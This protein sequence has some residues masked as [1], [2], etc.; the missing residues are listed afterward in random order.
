MI[1]QL[2]TTDPFWSNP[3]FQ[4]TVCIAVGLIGSLLLRRRSA[5]A[6][7]VLFLAMIAAVAVPAMSM[8]VRHYE[9]GM[10]VGKPAV[11]KSKPAEIPIVP[12]T[13]SYEISTPAPIHYTYSP[14]AI[15][16]E[17]AMPAAAVVVSPTKAKLPLSTILIWSWIIVSTILGVRL[18]MTFILGLGMLRRALPM[19]IAKGKLGIDKPVQVLAGN[20]V[21]SP[22][23]W[24]WS[25]RPALLVPEDAEQFED[26][27]DWVGMFCHELAHWSRLDHISGLFAEIMV[28]VFPWHPL[29]WWAKSRLAGL[30]EQACDDWVVAGSHSPT[31]YAE[32][33]LDLSPQGQLSFLPAVVGRKNGLES[34]IRRIVKDKCGKPHLGLCWAVFVTLIAACITIGAAFAQTRPA[35]TDQGKEGEKLLSNEHK[36]EPHANE[37]KHEPH[38]EEHKHELLA[39]DQ[40]LFAQ[41]QELLAEEQQ[42]NQLSKQLK[43]KQLE[44]QQLERLGS[45]LQL[46]Q[47]KQKTTSEVEAAMQL[48]L[49]HLKNLNAL[50]QQQAKYRK[51]A[52]VIESEIMILQQEQDQDRV[53]KLAAEGEPGLVLDKHE[54]ETRQLEAEQLLAELKA[55]RAKINNIENRLQA[56]LSANYVIRDP[57]LQDVTS[58][59]YGRTTQSGLFGQTTQRDQFGQATR[60]DQFQQTTERDQLTQYKRILKIEADNLQQELE[61][62]EGLRQDEIGN[63]ETHEQMRATLE[64]IDKNRHR[65]RSN[66]PPTL[67]GGEL[68][69]DDEL[70]ILKKIRGDLQIHTDKTKLKIDRLGD[71]KEANK[72]RGELDNIDAFIQYIDGRINSPAVWPQQHLQSTDEY[73]AKRKLL[74]PKRRELEDRRKHDQYLLKEAP[75]SEDAA[76]IRHELDKIDK[77]IREIDF[78]LSSPEWCAEK[79]KAKLLEK[80]TTDSE[81]VRRIEQQKSEPSC[82]SCHTDNDHVN[83]EKATIQAEMNLLKAQLTELRKNYDAEIFNRESEWWAEMR[84]FSADVVAAKQ[85]IVVAKAVL[86]DDLATLKQM[87]QETEIFTI[88]NSVNL[89]TDIALYNKLKTMKANHDRLGEKIERDKRVL[90]KYQD[91]LKAAEDRKD[92]YR[93]YKPTADTKDEDT[94]YAIT[95]FDDLVT[96]RKTTAPVVEDQWFTPPPQLPPGRSSRRR[97]QVQTTTPPPHLPPGRSSRRRQQIQ[98]TTQALQQGQAYSPWQQPQEKQQPGEKLQSRINQLQDEIRRLRTEMIEMRKLMKDLVEHEKKRPGISNLYENPTD[99]GVKRGKK[100]LPEIPG[101]PLEP[102]YIEPIPSKKKL[103]KKPPPKMPGAPLEPENI[104]P[105]P[106]EN[107]P[108]E[109]PPDDIPNEP[110]E[111]ETTEPIPLD[112]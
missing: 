77:E 17:Y 48:R 58:N 27:V 91:E 87:Q 1:S 39:H 6:H 59:L 30:S 47:L 76:I 56:S 73:E 55:L 63:A 111:I 25:R 36:H 53:K 92:K 82:S 52:D 95:E 81:I 68:F 90:A 29:I 54:K 60:S 3:L 97:Q 32:S 38:A 74:L 61:F 12:I 71:K 33:L 9:L 85:R 21:S 31:D 4:S 110:D 15:E 8:I 7:Q 13:T 16:P 2:F 94:D 75:N 93:K 78:E 107:K 109:H 98:T 112:D 11:T 66:V 50:A 18:F 105:T 45:Q 69:K 62:L 44:Q 5:R 19:H 108:H 96:Q 28:C 20:T 46:E 102:E 100:P 89:E 83:A 23:I 99:I 72:L 40:G 51:Q 64:A 43:L 57:L 106:I 84:A 70:A 86:E 34:R 65:I 49:T 22:V 80:W 88:E 26:G 79:R 103:P 42:L 10:F 104:E 101:E 37:H 35:D 67:I 14:P 24:C 41:Q